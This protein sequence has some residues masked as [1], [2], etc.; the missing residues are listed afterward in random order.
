[1]DIV[2]SP[3]LI[4]KLLLLCIIMQMV[5]TAMKLKNAYS[6]GGKL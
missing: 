2:L 5:I 6:L 1:M 3:S 4:S